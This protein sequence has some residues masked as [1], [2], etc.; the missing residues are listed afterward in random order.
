LAVQLDRRHAAAAPRSAQHGHG[1][2][3]LDQTYLY[4]RGLARLV[5]VRDVVTPDPHL[6]AA[7]TMSRLKTR[8]YDQS[9]DHHPE[10]WLWLHRR[11]RD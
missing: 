3:E 2:W 9:A 7:N 1:R 10:Q 6:R 5:L 11:W 4:I 8:D